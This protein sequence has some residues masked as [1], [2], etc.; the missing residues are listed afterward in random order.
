M[1]PDKTHAPLFRPKD[2][3]RA[4]KPTHQAE[5]GVMG[6]V[7]AISERF[8]GLNQNQRIILVATVFLIVLNL[9]LLFLSMK[10]LSRVLE[11]F[12]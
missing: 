12:G 8:T 11:R 10:I 4:K 6:F 7:K 1:P 3:L 9:A 5:A 2:G